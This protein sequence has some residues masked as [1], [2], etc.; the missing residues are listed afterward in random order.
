[1]LG[2]LKTKRASRVWY[3]GC[4][5][6]LGLDGLQRTRDFSSLL[7]VVLWGVRLLVFCIAILGRVVFDRC[8]V[9]V[10]VV[11]TQHRA[12]GARIMLKIKIPNRSSVYGVAVGL[13]PSFRR[14]K[15]NMIVL[16]S[17]PAA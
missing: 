7:W 1:T 16:D 13:R 14:Y 2:S 17:Q 11:H 3:C 5:I 6:T 9:N 4:P 12:V 8:A 15:A 10:R